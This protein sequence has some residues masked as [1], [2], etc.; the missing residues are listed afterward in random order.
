MKPDNPP[1][2]DADM[3]NA[4]AALIRAGK[5]ARELAAKTKTGIIVVRDGK[6][7][8]ETPSLYEIKESEETDD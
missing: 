8:R 3:Q 7:V 1:R 2:T 6:I 4:T 5:I